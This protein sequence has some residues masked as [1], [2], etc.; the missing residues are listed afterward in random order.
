MP[1]AVQSSGMWTLAQLFQAVG[2]STWK[3]ILEDYLWT[4]GTNGNGGLGDNTILSRSSPVQVDSLHTW[5]QISSGG[6]V[7]A[8]KT[9]GTIWN[10][11]GN[12]YG[13]L[14]NETVILRSSPVQVG[15]LTTWS[16]IAAG[17]YHSMAIKTDGTMWL[18]GRN[19]YSTGGGQLGDNTIISRSSPIQV[20]ALTTWSL[21]AAGTY[22]SIA[23]KTDGT[24]W[25]WGVGS[26]GALGV[27]TVL[28]RSSPVQIGALTTWS[29]ISGGLR[30]SMAIKTDGSLWAWGRAVCGQ[31]GD[32]TRVYRSSP[33][34]I[35]TTPIEETLWSQI[36]AGGRYSIATETDGT[37]WGWGRNQIGQ[38]G[39]NSVVYAT[40]P[41]QIGTLSTWSL[42]ATSIGY[43]TA[44]LK[45]DGTMWNWGSNTSGQLGNNTILPRSSPVQVGALTTWSKIANGEEFSMALKTD[46]TLWNWGYNFYAQLG[47]NTIINKSS[48][49]QVGAL[50]TWSQ[51]APGQH[52]S[53]ALKTDGTMWAWGR[54]QIGQLGDGTVISRS[55]PVQIGA[56]TTWSSI[57]GGGTFHS[58]AIKTDGTMW[59]WGD[60]SSDGRLGDG[61]QINRSSPVQVG[62]LT[63]WSKIAGGT[64]HS[65]AIKTDGT[66]WVWGKNSDGQLG[67]NTGSI[68]KSSPVQIGSLTTWSKIVGTEHTLA[69]ETDGALYGW[70]LNINDAL[71]DG[72]AANRS[73]PVQ[74]GAGNGQIGW[75]KVAA[76]SQQTLAIKTN[77]TMWSWGE[78]QGGGFGKLGLND[79]VYR[80]SPVQVGALT[81]WSQIDGGSEWC[82]AIKTDGTLWAWGSNGAGHLGD[83]TILSRSSPVQIGTLTTW[84][85]IT[86]GGATVGIASLPS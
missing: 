13:Q 39:R 49:I 3:G 10:W 9:D 11:G 71:G 48:P 28:N 76:N 23:T 25:S 55:S 2:A 41:V 33:V 34:Q 8:I 42:I 14:G 81:T 75:S 68:S 54:N 26:N 31:L 4:W 24:M 84:S 17:T 57:A 65:M 73:S 35:G 18:W 46:G 21:I 78:N 36:A 69:I 6:H 85:K 56:L 70:G 60:N 52:H 77:G 27:N 5:S 44:A 16:K 82:M 43:T 80:S 37:L 15:I 38:L 62:A 67:N 29:N 1:L 83:N 72:S 32:N 45:T 40:S 74:I 50:T 64:F 66:M 20:G 51:I 58:M 7:M 19:T 12:T 53:I 63:T 22:H 79:T 59:T 30:H 47:D 61:T 86:A